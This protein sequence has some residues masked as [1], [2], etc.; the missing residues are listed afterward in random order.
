[1]ATENNGEQCQPRASPVTDKRSPELLE[2]RSGSDN[3]ADK[4]A[5]RDIPAAIYST[6]EVLHM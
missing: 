3:S 2:I 1:M 6:C 4:R 5:K